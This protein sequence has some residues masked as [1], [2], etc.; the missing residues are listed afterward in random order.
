LL[1]L[2]VVCL[3]ACDPGGAPDETAS[4][5]HSVWAELYPATLRFDTST[6]NLQGAFRF[7]AAARTPPEAQSRWSRFLSEWD[8]PYGEFEDA[9]HANLVAWAKLERRRAEVFVNDP[10]DLEL[11]D[12]QLRAL[13]AQLE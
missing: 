1:A 6:D 10:A 3:A 7:A 2:L 4:P 11:I 12:Q 8:P 5:Y 13:A 9:M